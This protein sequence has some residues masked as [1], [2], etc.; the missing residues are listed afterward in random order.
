MPSL[1]SKILTDAENRWKSLLNADLKKAGLNWFKVRT[2]KYSPDGKDSSFDLRGRK[3]HFKSGKELLYSLKE[4]YI[5]ETYKINFDTKS[6]YILDCGAN[7]GLSI[8]YLKER[9]PG[10]RIIGFEPDDSNFALLQKNVGD[11][12]QV[13]LVKKAIWKESGTIQF[14]SEGS[15]SSKIASEGAAR[16]VLIPSARLKDYLTEKVDFLKLDIEGVEYE[17]LKDSASNLSMVD[18]LF[19]EYHGHFQSIDQLNEI[20]MLLR[21][22]NFFYYIREAAESYSTPFYRTGPKPP[23]D[24]QLNIFCFRNDGKF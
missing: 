14:A 12:D 21:E 11:L 9:F 8:L 16:T 24:L 20:L 5:D 4:I 2:L 19:I 7:I 10:A 13:T 1:I 22:N 17:V 23:Y 15:L 6:P 3:I 18:N